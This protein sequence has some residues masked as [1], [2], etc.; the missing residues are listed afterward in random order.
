[1]NKIKVL[2]ND[3]QIFQEAENRFEPVKNQPKPEDLVKITIPPEIL[4]RLW[5]NFKEYH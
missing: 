3:W 5:N 4:D 2:D 1:M